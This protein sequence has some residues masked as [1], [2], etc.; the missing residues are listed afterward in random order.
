MDSSQSDDGEELRTY[1]I[2]H[3]L[4]MRGSSPT[5]KP[6]A[7][8]D[9]IS[10]TPQTGVKLLIFHLD[11]SSERVMCPP[12]RLR[13]LITSPR[14]K[15]PSGHIMHCFCSPGQFR[16]TDEVMERCS[17]TCQDIASKTCSSTFF[18][19]CTKFVDSNTALHNLPQHTHLHLH[20]S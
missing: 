2:V 11:I 15:Q 3:I 16:A 5:R 6:S 20:F 19:P 17:S 4:G 7:R 9:Q 10:S 13:P 1:P 12:T 18:P 14:W 8:Q